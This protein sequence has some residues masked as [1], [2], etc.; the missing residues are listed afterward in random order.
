MNFT[1]SGNIKQRVTRITAN[2]Q[3]FP[4]QIHSITQRVVDIAK[5]L[6]LPI[7]QFEPPTPKYAYGQFPWESDKQRIAVMIKY[8]ELGITQYKRKGDTKRG[9]RLF[10]VTTPNGAQIIVRNEWDKAKY[11]YGQFTTEKPQQRFHHITGWTQA[12]TQ[13]E[14]I[15]KILLD[16]Y[17]D[18]IR[19]EAIQL[20]FD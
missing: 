4:Q 11:V 10:G 1:V 14:E 5:P 15:Y 19:D 6:I 18:V 13:R 12:K 20:L 17:R 8:K 9:W 2:L 7:L 3:A 16:T